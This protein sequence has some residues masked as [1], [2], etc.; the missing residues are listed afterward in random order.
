MSFRRVF[1]LLCIALA[2]GCSVLEERML[3][4]CFL[5]L[6]LGEVDSELLMEEGAASLDWALWQGERSGGCAE[7]GS[8][9]LSALPGSLEL[10]ASR[11]TSLDI[12]FCSSAGA[13]GSLIVP[14]GKD[15]QPI[16]GAT[17]HYPGGIDTV[18]D[19][20]RLHRQYAR[21][22]FYFKGGAQSFSIVTLQGDC[23]G[24]NSDLSIARGP[25][26]VRLMPDKT[27]SCSAAVPRQD[28]TDLTLCLQAAGGECRYFAIGNY[29][30]AGGYD[31]SA[32]DLD[33]I[34]IEID[35][36]ASR[37]SLYSDLWQRSVTFTVT[38]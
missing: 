21:I 31:W 33:D 10:Q 3:C 14:Q 22:Y 7:E 36:V 16:Y 18:S 1:L 15:C 37:V 6:D 24:Y 32:P 20:L 27:S 25:F 23:C 26:S 4:P 8:E 30:L 34:Y 35:C 5:T 13:G 19:T 11:D 9:L 29:I 12:I 38:L 17:L 28:G 2:P